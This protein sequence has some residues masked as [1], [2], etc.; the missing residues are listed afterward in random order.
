MREGVSRIVET[1]DAYYAP[2]IF[3]SILW[4]AQDLAVWYYGRRCVGGADWRRFVPSIAVGVPVGRDAFD[5]TTATDVS[6]VTSMALEAAP[7]IAVAL[8][9][10]ILD[11]LRSVPR[12]AQ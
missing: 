3:V 7:F 9:S 4:C 2:A 11:A 8:N 5:T 12:A 6:A 1:R 10:D